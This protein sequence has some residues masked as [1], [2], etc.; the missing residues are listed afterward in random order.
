MLQVADYGFFCII[1]RRLQ[2]LYV[3]AYIFLC[4][5]V[6]V[7]HFFCSSPLRASL[8]LTSFLQFAETDEQQ[9]HRARKTKW[10]PREF[11]CQAVFL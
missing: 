4:M 3:R 10:P 8:T 9:K 5:H 7:V 2:C 1:H 11:K 6:A